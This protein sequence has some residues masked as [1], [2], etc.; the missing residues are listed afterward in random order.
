MFKYN[1]IKINI[2]YRN[3]TH[4]IK[5][6]YK[7]VL[8]QELEI[9]ISHLPSSSHVRIDVICSICESEG[10]IIYCKYIENKKRHGFYGC[11]KCSRQ[12]AALTSIEKYGVDNYS[13]T[14]EWKEK[15]EK[16]N[17]E[18]YGFKTNLLSPEHIENNKKILL[19]KYNTEKFYEINRGK[20]KNK[21]KLKD[22]I[23]NLMDDI[24]L[25]EDL[26]D[27]SLLNNDYLLYRNECRRFTKYNYNKLIEDWDGIDYYDNID[28]LNNF[29]LDHNDPNYPTIDHKIS[30]YYGFKNSIDPNI[31]GSID[32]LCITKRS[33]NSSKRHLLEEEFT[34]YQKSE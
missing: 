23:F 26:Y 19:Q 12:K 16:T 31:I 28:I 32:N 22:D 8:G 1:K 27:S 18:K 4:Y 17:V 9:N 24:T 6:G 7:P 15:V 13:K 20:C 5:L 29:E 34:N 30:V 2:S 3:I 21:F 33:I 11:K 14:D 10:N 25:S